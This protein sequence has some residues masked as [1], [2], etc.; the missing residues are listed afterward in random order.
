MTAKRRIGLML[1]SVLMALVV[2]GCGGGGE[3]ATPV[4]PTAPPPTQ[5]PTSPPPPPPTEPP[6]AAPTEAPPTAVPTEEAAPQ[7]GQPEI[8][9]VHGYIDNMD[10]LEVVGLITN[11]TDHAIK[12]VEI[13]VEIFDANDNSLY[14]DTTY[15]DFYTLAPGE[16]SPFSLWVTDELPDADRFVAT[17]VSESQT[18]V[19]RADVTVQGT[20]MTVD[21]NGDI[22]VTGEIVNNGST[23]ATIAD[24]SAATFDGDGNL[25][26]AESASVSIGYLP[27]GDSGPF[28]VTMYGPSYGTDDIQDYQV[29]VDA[30][31]DDRDVYDISFIGDEN[32]YVDTFGDFHLV[33]EISNDSDETLDVRL[34]GAIYD[35]NGN[36]MDAAMLD[37][38]L[39]A[40]APGETGPY[41]L[42]FWGPLNSRDGF[43]DDAD[44]YTV[45]V[46]PYW[47]WPST[48]EYVEVSTTEDN[49][50]DDG[51][52]EF[53]GQIINDSGQDLAGAEVVIYIKDKDSGNIVAMGSDYTMDEIPAG[54]TADF[55]I[56]IY[57]E[58]GVDPDTAEYY[59][60]AKGELP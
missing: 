53:T 15:M 5:A 13:A 14:K 16:T 9:M 19:E 36:V 8:T 12:S 58:E 29:Y 22:H 37:M 32:T 24:V 11:N 45:Q 52:A 27:P 44:R 57:L 51:M 50:F 42:T 47:T 2:F 26:T 30:V 38:A 1:L 4:P 21:D 46:D 20:R 28:R 34:V 41:D 39:S 55:S 23:G 43:M 17:I 56:T 40:L 10:S 3:E 49:S 54:G 48:S 31:T 25:V 7:E 6:T 60:I 18:T 33:G 35:A 59:V